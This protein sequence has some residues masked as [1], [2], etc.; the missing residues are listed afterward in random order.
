MIINAL[1]KFKGFLKDEECSDEDTTPEGRLPLDDG[2]SDS[3]DCVLK[4]LLENL[5]EKGTEP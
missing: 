2:E 5:R 4:Q 3:S 1:R